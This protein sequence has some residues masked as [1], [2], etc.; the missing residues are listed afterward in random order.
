MPER[1]IRFAVGSPEGPRSAIWSLVGQ[2]HDAYIIP[3]ELKSTAK[4]SL[5]LRT[6]EFSW[7]YT[8]EYFNNNRDEIKERS[9]EYGVAV[10]PPTSRDFERWR[11]PSEFGS[12]LTLPIRI[13][14]ANE[15]LQ[16]S[17][18]LPTDQPIRWVAPKTG[19]AVGFVF[20][21]VAASTPTEQ[22]AGHP[23]L[24]LIERLE[25]PA[26][27]QSIV[28]VAHHIEA[29]IVSAA[30]T[31]SAIEFA[32]LFPQFKF[33]DKFRFYTQAHRSPRLALEI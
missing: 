9:K 19:R 2:K 14:V 16:T 5:H 18:D 25:F 1:K 6:G 31:R 30:A 32:E 10:S 8:S 28:V 3:L 33:P 17:T 11:Q 27:N 4:I 21:L 20:L 24:E 29:Q 23:D 13:Y 7:G 26:R 15:A 12:G 22:V